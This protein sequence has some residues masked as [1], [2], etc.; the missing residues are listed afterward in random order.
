MNT[1]I[2]T[3]MPSI[4]LDNSRPDIPLV[5]GVISFTFLI[6]SNSAN[7]SRCFRDPEVAGSAINSQKYWRSIRSR[8]K[9]P[10]FRVQNY[11]IEKG[12]LHSRAPLEHL[13]S[14][15]IGVQL[16]PWFAHS[17]TWQ[18]E[19]YKFVQTVIY[20]FCIRQIWR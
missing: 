3:C 16:R 18:V 11:K 7:L 8:S 2:L 9:S 19:F 12:L 5:K 10:K 13:A 15:E 4:I 1:L 20:L 14:W 17:C 6:Q